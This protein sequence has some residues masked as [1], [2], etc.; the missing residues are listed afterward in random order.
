M[1][2]V[3]ENQLSS[4]YWSAALDPGVDE[5]TQEEVREQQ[6]MRRRTQE[7]AAARAAAAAPPGAAAPAPPPPLPVPI[8]P[9]L[10]IHVKRREFFVVKALG[11]AAPR[12]GR[13]GH[14]TVA[15]QVDAATGKARPFKSSQA[16]PTAGPPATP[17][18]APTPEP[19]MAWCK[20]GRDFVLPSDYWEVGLQHLQR[21]LE[22]AEESDL[23]FAR[24]MEGFG[25]VNPSVVW[26][27]LDPDFDPTDREAVMAQFMSKYME[28][29]YSRLD[30]GNIPSVE[31]V[32]A[33]ALHKHKVFCK[34]WAEKH[35]RTLTPVVT[36]PAEALAGEFHAALVRKMPDSITLRPT[37]LELAR[38]LMRHDEFAPEFA[39]ALHYYM[40]NLEQTRGGRNAN[41]K[42][43]RMMS[44]ARV[45]SYQ[46]LGKML[47][48]KQGV[49]LQVLAD[50]GA[51]EATHY[52]HPLT[53]DWYA[54]LGQAPPV[55]RYFEDASP[56][57][58]LSEARRAT[59]EGRV[60]PWRFGRQ[61]P[62]ADGA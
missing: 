55:H 22:E 7:A 42:Q 5:E 60:P 28:K 13:Q 44:A 47:A 50:I 30:G 15:Y 8:A 59:A 53:V 62:A 21:V 46:S 10:R 29:F 54:I 48:E 40:A 6:A 32:S 38:V 9:P 36:A 56:Y 52:L 14:Y 35:Y 33:E 27:C 3:F 12:R 11:S 37:R 17:R 1:Q 41:Y 58:G 45:T 4:N 31:A 51:S 57:Q 16:A 25:N 34:A 20:E 18:N 61:I 26:N 39:S 43:I 19:D 23:A 2:G 24:R 49:L